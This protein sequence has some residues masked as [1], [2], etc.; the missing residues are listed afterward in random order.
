[1]K[2]TRLFQLALF[3]IFATSCSSDDGSNGGQST[4]GIA[5]YTVNSRTTYNDGQPAQ[6]GFVRANLVNGKYFSETSFNP[7]TLQADTQQYYFYENN[8]IQSVGFG[9]TGEEF[10]YDASGRVTAR[11]YWTDTMDNNYYRYSYPSANIVFADEYS[12]AH[13]VAGATLMARVIV[14]FD[15]NDN[16]I[17]AGKDEDFDGVMDQV[18]QYTYANNNMVEMQTQ[19]G[20]FTWD[21]TSVINNFS[22]LED[23]T[24]GRRLSRLRYADWYATG[25]IY[26][27]DVHSISLQTSAFE[28]GQYEMF[29]N[30]LFKKRTMQVAFGVGQSSTTVEFFLN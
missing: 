3:A 21:Y 30:G 11:D 26:T 7:V 10:F 9:Y 1:M 24:F 2:T 17:K 27:L 25:N 5:Y 22:I 23:N 13:D 18:S 19:S 4:N 20:A 14:E 12:D 15:A 8:R 29:A 28:N 6:E 16:I